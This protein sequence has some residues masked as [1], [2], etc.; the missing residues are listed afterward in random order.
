MSDIELEL[1]KL[2]PSAPSNQIQDYMHLP[3]FKEHV[4]RLEKLANVPYVNP[5][6][7]IAFTRKAQIDIL[8]ALLA[9]ASI[10]IA[11][12]LAKV[13]EK[14]FK[15]WESLAARDIEPYASFIAE[16]KVAQG[17]LDMELIQKM[18]AGGWK[19][20]SELWRIRY[21][22]MQAE[23]PK[24]APQLTQVINIMDRKPEER[25]DIIRGAAA[26]LE[27]TKSTDIL[28]YSKIIDVDEDS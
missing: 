10:K 17:L 3:N 19:G 7:V 14:A 11:L 5:N 9:G 13:K 21:P 25:L 2:K 27:H 16:V 18:R 15:F 1:N 26:D 23:G 24:S 8:K 6:N 20:A 4:D 12:D 22:E 28:D